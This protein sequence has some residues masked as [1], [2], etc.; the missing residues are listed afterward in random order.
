[1]SSDDGWNEKKS[2]L[3]ASNKLPDAFYGQGILTDV[4][5][6]K[7]ASQGM[8]IPLNDL[9]DEYAPNLRCV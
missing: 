7:Y 8:L 2:L 3:F 6:M 1:M 5:I 4:D 9:I